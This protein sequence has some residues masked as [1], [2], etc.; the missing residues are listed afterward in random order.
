MKKFYG[1][2]QI[3]NSDGEIIEVFKI[4]N[5]TSVKLEA[6]NYRGCTDFYEDKKEANEFYQSKL[7]LKTFAPGCKK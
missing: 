2:V 5:T 7:I 3:F 6:G 1:V 4:K